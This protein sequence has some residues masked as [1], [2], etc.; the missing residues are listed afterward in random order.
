[1]AERPTVL[2]RSYQIHSPV[3]II[4]YSNRIEVINPGFSL[5]DMADLGSPGSRL[6]NP[7]I[8]AVLHDLHWAETKGSGIRTMRR[9]SAEAGLPLPEFNSDRQRNEFKAILLLHH[10]LTEDDYRWLRELAG[11]TLTA[12]EAKVLIYTRETGAVDNT[13]CRDLSGL[14]TL[15]ASRVLRRLRDKGLLEKQEAGAGP[16]TPCLTLKGSLIG[17]R[18]KDAY[19]LAPSLAPL[20]VVSSTK[21]VAS[22]GEQTYHPSLLPCSGQRLSAS[23]LR[24]LIRELCG[25]HSLRGEELA[26][27]SLGDTMTFSSRNLTVRLQP[28]HL[29]EGCSDAQDH[30]SRLM[31]RSAVWNRN[32]GSS[33]WR[34]GAVAG[35]LRKPMLGHRGWPSDLAGTPGSPDLEPAHASRAAMHRGLHAPIKMTCGLLIV[36]R[37]RILPK[38]QAC[39]SMEESSRGW[40]PGV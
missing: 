15:A 25:W 13:A 20:K 17:T 28:R 9:L 37:P 23:E 8:A 21:K 3:Q 40:L 1:M 6:R 24:Q 2:N 30:R 38:C 16:I 18:N 39:T 34:P 33:M 4:R 19:H 10:L 26:S 22:L 31:S 14:D 12:E 29:E 11:N 7:A 35:C 36:R 5:K 27:R 32:H